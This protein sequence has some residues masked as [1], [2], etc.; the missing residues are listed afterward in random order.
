M[1]RIS[2]SYQTPFYGPKAKHRLRQFLV[3][4]AGTEGYGIDQLSLVFCSD[5]FL[6]QMN[7]SYLGHDYHTDIITFDL[8]EGRGV[9]SGEL[10]I[11]LDRVRENAQA[12]KQSFQRELHRVMIHGLLHLCGYKDKL[13]AD[14]AIMREKEDFYLRRYFGP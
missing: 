13:K 2:F 12:W 11:S 6:K 9:I 8:S 5:K 7:R 3:E 1:A 14:Q 4:L 10:Y